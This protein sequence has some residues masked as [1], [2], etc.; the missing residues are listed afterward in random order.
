[1]NK[2]LCYTW[3]KQSQKTQKTKTQEECTIPGKKA[4]YSQTFVH[5]KEGLL[6]AGESPGVWE[7]IT[8]L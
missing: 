7:G 4:W 1:M 2:F 8:G 5:S 3:G 6:T